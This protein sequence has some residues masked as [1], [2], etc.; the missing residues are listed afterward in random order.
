MSESKETSTSRRQFIKYGV[1]GAVG[2]GV[3]SA[4]ELPIL[5]NVIQNDNSQISRLQSENN[6][7]QSQNTTL[8]NQNTNL[9][10]Q[11]KSALQGQGFL[12]LNPNERVEV[13][14]I[15]EAMIPSDSNGP[16]AKEAGV[17]YF[18]DRMLAGSYGKGGNYYLQGPF[19][20]PQSGSVTV[21]GAIYPD[22]QKKPITY[23]GGTITP[24]LQAGTAYQYAFNP[25]EFWR[26]GLMFLEDYCN[27]AF[28]NKFENLTVDQQTQVLKNLFNN[29][30]T[31]MQ[32]FSGPTP[33]EFFNELH[34]M[35]TAGFWTDPLYGGNIGMV[36]WN[37]LA[38]PGV[39]S[40]A[41]QG[42][43]SEELMTATTPTRLPAMSLADLQKGGTM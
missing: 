8:Q 36:G 42:H 23:P 11:L 25:R 38:F 15:A 34:D 32:F 1:A 17:V 6:Q 7:L 39:N 19:V 37:L 26:R 30:V 31:A 21:E 16:G 10:N 22:T 40:G 27:S 4:V 33:A 14:A 28:S 18:I 41:A 24:R 29:N 20:M 3:A 2:F 9:Q 5:N 43:T 13:E 35:V 12:T